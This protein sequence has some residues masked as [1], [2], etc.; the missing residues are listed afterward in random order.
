M[1][2]SSSHTIPDLTDIFA[3]VDAHRQEFL[4]RLIDYVRRP[5]ISTHG[6]GIGEVASYIANVMQ[7]IG[8]QTR[9]L[10]TAGWT[11][12]LGVRLDAQ[13]GPTILLYWHYVDKQPES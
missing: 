7:R 11:M 10:P 8:L 13:G 12:V 1:N 3:Y 6:Q 5:S 2:T 9:I 4:D